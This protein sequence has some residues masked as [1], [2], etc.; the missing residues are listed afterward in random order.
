MIKT[1]NNSVIVTYSS[2]G[3]VSIFDTNGKLIA[4]LV[5]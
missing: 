3:N 4:N 2:N 1:T 5:E